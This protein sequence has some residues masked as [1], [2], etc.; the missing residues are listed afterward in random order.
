MTLRLTNYGKRVLSITALII[1][2]AVFLFG[3]IVC[4][5][6]YASLIALPQKAYNVLFI[7]FLMPLIIC[8]AVEI[9]FNLADNDKNTH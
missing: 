6:E 4:L 2:T 5:G 8:S 3:S 1:L 7:C 9:I